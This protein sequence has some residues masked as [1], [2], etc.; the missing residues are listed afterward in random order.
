MFFDKDGELDIKIQPKSECNQDELWKCTKYFGD[1]D[2]VV[3]NALSS[4]PSSIPVISGPVFV[5]SGEY[6]VKTDII[7][8]KN[9]KTQTEQDIHFETIIV[10]P[11]EQEFKITVSGT[12]YLITTKNF[13]DSISTLS[14]D[15]SSQSLILQIPF[16]WTHLDH[17][18]FIKNYIEIPKNFLP[19]NGVD[20][21]IG[22]I[23]ENVILPKDLHYD[24]FSNKNSNIIH[25]MINN[26]ELK[27]LKNSDLKLN[28]TLT[29]EYPSSVI[30]QDL[31]FD[32][33][34]KAHVS[35]D[36]RYSESKDFVF[37]IVFFDQNGQIFDD[38]RYG[39][40]I[41]DPSGK[42]IVNTGGNPNH[43]G[44]LLPNGIDTR[45]LDAPLE[46]KYSMQIVLLGYGNN[47]FET[48]FFKKFDIEM[49]KSQTPK[50]ITTKSIPGWIKSNAGWWA[51][52]KIDDDSFVQG[53]QFLIKEK[54]IN[55]P[56]TS[57]S[58][59]VSNEIPP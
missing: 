7:G 14:Y 12:E 57:N 30:S 35:Y 55:I 10:I 11:D 52:G 51:D 24:K 41:T 13:Q 21:F 1:V 34:I 37:S 56:L 22:K 45:T 9:P 50:T 19:F 5:K 40:G 26:D 36:S 49:I 32:N 2:P 20:S 4:T 18:S 44:I 43:M 42:E 38:L 17:V 46:G 47:D 31:L 27:S 58:V 39:Y 3:P 15:E 23:N 33:G 8:A 16:D 48:L 25:F 28:L 6:T 54:I 53:I 29:P 59:T